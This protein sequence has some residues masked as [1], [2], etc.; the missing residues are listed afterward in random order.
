MRGT[1]IL[2]LMPY[3]LVR[4]STAPIASTLISVLEGAVNPRKLLYDET[5]AKIGSLNTALGV[6]SKYCRTPIARQPFMES[7]VFL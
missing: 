4:A 6:S 2:C 5:C 7:S 3:T 1:K